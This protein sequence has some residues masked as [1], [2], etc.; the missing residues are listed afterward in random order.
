MTC[1]VTLV[2]FN[3]NHSYIV[4]FKFN[5]MIKEFPTQCVNL[6]WYIQL[7]TLIVVH[8]SLDEYIALISKYM[9]HVY[10]LDCTHF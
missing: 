6:L 5:T 10:M 4:R 1:N 8:L 7:I 2:G 3:F 9:V